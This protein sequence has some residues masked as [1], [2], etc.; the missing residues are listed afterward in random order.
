[1]TEQE[2]NDI[3]L[4]RYS[5]I[6]PVITKTAPTGFKSDFFK[7]A[8]EKTY[9]LPNGKRAKFSWKTIEKWYYSYTKY[10]FDVLKPMGRS[11]LGKNRKLD[12]EAQQVIRHYVEK[13]PRMQATS[14]FKRLIEDGYIAVGDVSLPTITR[15]IKSFKDKNNIITSKEYKRYEVEHINDVWCCDTSYSFKLT[16]NGEKKRTYII[17]IIDDASRCIVGINVF[18]EDNKVNFMSVLKDAIKKFGKPKLLNLDNGGPYKNKQLELLAARVGIRLHHC[19]AF[20]PE[21]IM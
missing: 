20:S 18:F 17:A 10:G 2:K 7:E 11:D 8:G 4:L 3:A 12:D 15:Y 1:M 14:I 5:I 21:S 13:Y 6:A 9:T 19:E 16:V